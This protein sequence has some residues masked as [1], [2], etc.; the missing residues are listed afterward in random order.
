MNFLYPILFHISRGEHRHDSATVVGLPSGENS[1]MIFYPYVFRHRSPASQT[2]GQTDRETDRRS[3][4]TRR[5]PVVTVIGGS[6]RLGQCVVSDVLY[7]GVVSALT[8]D[9]V[10]YQLLSMLLALRLRLT[11]H[12]HALTLQPTPHSTLSDTY[13]S[14][15]ALV[16]PT[17]IILSTVG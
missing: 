4:R 1:L 7:D 12:R 2:D 14:T 9:D 11:R 16:L 5:R 10:C 15:L 8:V 6:G 13:Y 3:D 17:S